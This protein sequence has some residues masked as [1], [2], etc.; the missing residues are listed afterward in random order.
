LKRWGCSNKAGFNARPETEVIVRRRKYKIRI[1]DDEC[2]TEYTKN[3]LAGIVC[4]YDRRL[5]ELTMRRRC[6]L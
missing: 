6:S 3:L 2:G 4:I 1:F 5:I